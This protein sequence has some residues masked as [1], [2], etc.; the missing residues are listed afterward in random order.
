MNN[1]NFFDYLLVMSLYI[2][3][4]KLVG[5]DYLRRLLNQA[6]EDCY[7]KYCTFCKYIKLIRLELFKNGYQTF[8]KS[9]EWWKI[10]ETSTKIIATPE[11][12]N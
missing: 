4:D 3:T 9:V 1:F 8:N 7:C 6:N 11:I 5:R 12:D 2:K 10:T